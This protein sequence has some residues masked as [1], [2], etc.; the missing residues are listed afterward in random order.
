MMGCRALLVEMN[1]KE[2]AILYI[3]KIDFFP[4]SGIIQIKLNVSHVRHVRETRE[5]RL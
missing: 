1:K 4:Q 5:K 2:D 3:N